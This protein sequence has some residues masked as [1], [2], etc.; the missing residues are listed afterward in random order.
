MST[1]ALV[2][3]L[4]DNGEDFEWYPT[5][6]DMIETVGRKLKTLF[7][8][9]FSFMDIGAGD[10]RVI[11]A[12][13]KFHQRY[14]KRCERIEGGVSEKYAIEKSPILIQQ[15]ADDIT[16]VGTDFLMQTL[17]DKKV[18][19]I[20][21]NPPYS[22][23][24]AWTNRILRECNCGHVF[25]IIPQRWKDNQQ[26]ADTIKKREI[27]YEVL[28]SNDFFNAERQAR[29]KV[30]IIYFNLS[31]G[32][33]E[34]WQRN[35]EGPK[36]D[37][38]EVWFEDYF[39]INLDKKSDAGEYTAERAK[40]EAEKARIEGQ[41]V[42]GKNH[43]T[44][45]AELYRADLDKLM[46]N[47]QAVGNLDAE[48]LKE[49]GVSVG[50][51]RKA[52]YQKIVGLKTLYWKEL[53]NKLE[54]ITDR[55]TSSTRDA[56]LKRLNSQM[57]VDFTESN[58]YAVIIWALKNVNKYIDSQLLEV[59]LTLTCEENARNYKSNTHMTKDTWRYCYSG[60]EKA[61]ISHYTLD[62]RMVLRVHGAITKPGAYS[63]E[64][65]NGLANRAHTYIG[66]VF[67]VAKNLGFRV[68]GSTFDR[69]WSSNKSNTFYYTKP[70]GTEGVFAEIRAF[71]NG[72][73]HVKFNQEF[74]KALNIEAGRL[75]NWIKSPKEAEE[76][77]GIE[78]ADQFF[79][80]NF[81]ITSVPMLGT[82]TED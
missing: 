29:A 50:G 2:Q 33:R 11:E 65:S 48:I 72:N 61:K 34:S 58:V 74:V 1:T 59:Y 21:C 60:E 62:Y 37:P 77:M 7:D 17:I 56:M 15:M 8:D 78:D 27:K 19:A 57:N 6:S 12:I 41:L 67:T 22:E 63:W 70:D 36:V 66:D 52:L 5:S 44:V 38:F 9:S 24:E 54:S 16:I 39:K 76:E 75:N 25:L 28:S 23:Y 40:E 3:E 20:F 35:V 82:G 73:I 30:D 79:M 68:L 69:G 4:K 55:L 45:L 80:T 14:D 64:T 81:K 46:K 71:M 42:K 13:D 18:D 51:L 26:I 32:K 31:G 43:V 49:L 53:F 47:Y 10:G